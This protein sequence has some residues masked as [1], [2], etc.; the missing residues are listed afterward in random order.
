MAGGIKCILCD[1]LRGGSW[2]QNFVPGFFWTLAHVPFPFAEFALNQL[3]VISHSHKYNYILS[4][5]SPPGKSLYLGVVLGIPTH[6]TFLPVADCYFP[7]MV[8][9]CAGIAHALT[10]WFWHS[11]HWEA[12][13]MLPP[14]EFG[15]TVTMM[16]VM[17]CDFQSSWL[18][19]T[20]LPP[21][22]LFAILILR[23][24][25]PC[26][27]EPQAGTRSCCTVVPS[28]VLAKVPADSQHQ[29]PI[30]TRDVSNPS[31]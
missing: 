27:E 2:S 7:K 31:T 11:S 28:T 16:E 21:G 17:L 13:S 25:S 6:P 8:A 4:F 23:T 10:M 3:A 5:M 26:C 20:Q 12:E 29:L 14:L 9:T 19:V 30:G 22:S 24:Q 18:K 15:W 1:S